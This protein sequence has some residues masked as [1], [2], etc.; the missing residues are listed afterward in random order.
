MRSVYITDTSIRI[1]TAVFPLTRCPLTSKMR[2]SVYIG[3]VPI[4]PG[5]GL[6][7]SWPLEELLGNK[8]YELHTDTA[9]VKMKTGKTILFWRAGPQSAVTTDLLLLGS[10]YRSKHKSSETFK[11]PDEDNEVVTDGAVV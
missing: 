2:S 4:R 9:D 5:R 7:N 10:S 1:V 8:T 3:G 11:S 6:F